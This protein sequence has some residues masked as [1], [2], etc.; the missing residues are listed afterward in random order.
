MKIIITERNALFCSE[1]DKFLL[2]LRY[3][4]DETIFNKICY[5]QKLILSN[6]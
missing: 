2:Y 3:V 1:L 6:K 4:V 5:N